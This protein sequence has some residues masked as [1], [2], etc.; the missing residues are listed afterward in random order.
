MLNLLLRLGWEIFIH[1]P[2]TPDFVPSDFHLFHLMK[3]FLAGKRFH[4]D[5]EIQM[6]VTL[7][8]QMLVVD[9]YDAGIET[10]VHW[11]DKCNSGHA[12]L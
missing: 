7:W 4:N 2:Y 3:H 5:N 8:F 1:S 10:L 6:A 12:V 9:S 11:F